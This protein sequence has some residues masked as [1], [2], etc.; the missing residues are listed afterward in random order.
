[1]KIAFK[2]FLIILWTST[3][4]SCTKST[5]SIE[6]LRVEYL[7]EPIG[8]DKIN[9]LLSWQLTSTEYGKYQSAYQILVASSKEA[10]LKN[11]ADIYN[12]GKQK[13]DNTV[14][15]KLPISFKSNAFYYWKVKMWDENDSE[16]NFSEIAF[17]KTG[18]LEPADWKATW[19]SNKFQEVSA[20]REPFSSYDDSRTYNSKDTAAVYMYNS[21][22]LNNKVKNATAYVSGLGYYELYIN[23]NKVGNHVLDPVFT[24]YQQNVKYVAYDVTSMLQENK[25]NALAAI[26]GNG[27]YNHNQPDLFQME[28]AN[29][30]TPPKLLC[31]IVLEFKDGTK[32]QITTNQ[33]WKWSYGPI[34]YNSI[35]GGETI[36]AR[37]NIDGWNTTNFDHKIWQDVVEVPAPVGELSF[38]YMPPMRETNTFQ[39]DT[40][41]QISDNVTV[42]DFG[43]NITGYADIII[44]GEEG[45]QVDFYFN[46][47]LNSDGSLNKRHSASHTWGRFQHGKLILS[48]K[49]E[50][51]FAP[52]FTYHGFRYVQVEGVSA[53]DIVS[54]EAKSVFT[55]I[56]T[57]STFKSSNE[58]LNQLHSAVKRTLLNSVHSMPGEEATR[59][60]MGWTYDG[61]MNT[62]ESY[63]YNFDITNTFKKYLAD[64]IES[65]EH[66]GHVPPIVPTNGWGFLEKTEKGKDTIIQYDDPWWGGTLHYVAQELFEATGDTA[67]IKAAYLPIKRHTD[68]VLNT[69]EEDIVYW[70][71]GD[72]LD[73]EHN[74][75]GWGPGL[76]SV[77]LTSTAGLYYLCDITAQSA[78]LL[79][80]EN[81]AKD[82]EAKAKQVKEAFNEKFLD[83]E[84]GWYD[85]KS[86]T[87]Q[88]VPLYYGLVP[89]SIID[90]AEQRLLES[91]EANN[92]HTS[93][94]F[95]GVRPLIQYLS[96]NGHKA[97]MYRLLAQEE[98]PGWL[99]FVKDH[100]S[101]MGE[102]LNSQGYGT[103]HHPFATN[104]GFW[105]FEHL[106]GIKIDFTKTP[107]IYLNPGLEADVDWVK[108]SS[109]TLLGT[110]VNEWDKKA[111]KVNYHIEIPVNTTAKLVIPPTY[112]LENIEDYIAKN[113]VEILGA[114]NTYIIKSGKYDLILV[115]K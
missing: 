6:N 8:I 85:K 46:E 81:E 106:S 101:T 67:I 22:K 90:K 13:S 20:K 23:G 112:T 17:W 75:N 30:K 43:E 99:H 19:I 31:Q 35:R 33:N 29:W 50:D 100:R 114:L 92:Y 83:K 11:E 21:F 84:T 36:D 32:E 78:R 39:P 3:I 86:Q 34:V 14:N 41:W 65:Q 28:K 55:D 60:K 71:L 5:V 97:L 74:K 18:L 111:D 51:I 79:G 72:W 45:K 70:S 95:I 44:K 4:S 103:N 56:R 115:K 27:F 102:N 89:D 113:L 64:L 91:I 108:T 53:E 105:L 93:V 57:N 61:G 87:G 62:M 109:E 73:L 16:T 15:I 2:I 42:Y 107:K 7:E 37:I 80:Y 52:R 48:N 25:E 47:S 12:S 63:L 110:I 98:S 66:N 68:F 1:M 77:E 59:E 94:G 49:N 82:Y 69:A 9:P 26:L 96:E 24:D 54:I 10:L 40:L 104:I 38:Q 88:S 58:R 76:T